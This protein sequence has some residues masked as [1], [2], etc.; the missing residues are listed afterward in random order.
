[1]NVKLIIVIG[2][3]VFLLIAFSDQLF[4]DG[5]GAFFGQLADSIRAMF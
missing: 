3:A 1:M 5:V 2:L 4:P